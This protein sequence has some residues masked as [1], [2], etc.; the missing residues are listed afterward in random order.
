MGK[1]LRAWTSSVNNLSKRKPYIGI[2]LQ[3]YMQNDPSKPKKPPV[4]KHT[5]KIRS[6]PPVH[7]CREITVTLEDLK[8]QASLFPLS[9]ALNSHKINFS[10]W[11]LFRLHCKRDLYNSSVLPT[12]TYSS[13]TTLPKHCK[14]PCLSL[15]WNV[16]IYATCDK[17]FQA[18]CMIHTMI[19]DKRHYRVCQLLTLFTSYLPIFQQIS[20]FFL[21]KHTKVSCRS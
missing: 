14:I 6:C 17:L 10:S 3:K 20:V 16:K 4:F 2:G 18:C 11:F 1:N 19:G 12:P 21:L 9:Q 13:I 8:W 5:N 7:A 15:Y